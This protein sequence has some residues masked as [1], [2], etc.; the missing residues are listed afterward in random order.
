MPLRV[1][2]LGCGTSMGVPQMGCRCA[3]C[4]SNDPRNQR[5][6]PAVHL[7]TETTRV[8]I[9]APPELRLQLIRAGLDDWLNAVLITHTHA[10]HIMG[11]DDVRG[12]TLRTGVPMPV[13]A[14][15]N[16]LEDLRRVFRYVF[17]PFPPGVSTPQIEFR[18]MPNPLK[19]GDM[20]IE[21]LQVFHGEMP[22]LAF[23]VGGFAYVTDVNYIPPETM[24][25]LQGLELLILDALRHAPHPTHFNLEQA[26]AMAQKLGAKRTL[27]TH[28][29]HDLD[30][31][32]TNAQLP[33]GIELA[34]DGQIVEIPYANLG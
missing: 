18:E 6:R 32:T 28:M 12:F 15:A 33:N 10:D 9:D 4:T 8:L 14:D 21:P 24:E 34:Y 20:V 29:T 11:L 16:A 25:R 30:Y 17:F 31:S 1:T 27:F 19:V 7:A 5:T 2:I 26:V 3:V 13:Y 23:R 22:V